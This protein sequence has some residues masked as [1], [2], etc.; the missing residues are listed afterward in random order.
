MGGLQH[1]LLRNERLRQTKQ[2]NNQFVHLR[3]AEAAEAAEVAEYE[4]A[5]CHCYYFRIL[6]G[7]PE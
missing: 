1:R 3:V 2:R 7:A 5:W 4:Q 6:Q